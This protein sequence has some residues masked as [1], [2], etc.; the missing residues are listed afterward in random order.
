MPSTSAPRDRHR[1]GENAAAAAD[2]D[3]ALPDEITMA[4][5]VVQAQR[6]DV[7]QRPKLA[8]G[9]PPSM[10]ERFEFRDF[11]MIDVLTIA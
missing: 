3:D 10:R 2:V 7:V 5:D 9:I 1:F 11:R 8:F 6:I 4:R